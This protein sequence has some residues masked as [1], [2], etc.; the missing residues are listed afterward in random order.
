[1]GILW[2]KSETTM[3]KNKPAVIFA[4][5]PLVKSSHMASPDLRVRNQ[6]PLDKSFCNIIGQ[7]SL[8]QREVKKWG[9]IYVQSSWSPPPDYELKNQ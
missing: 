5:D 2:F 1:M 4:D 7:K 6:T 3:C 8:V 9:Y